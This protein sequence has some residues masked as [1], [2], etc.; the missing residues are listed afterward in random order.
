MMKMLD[1]AAVGYRVVLTKADKVKQSE[2]DKVISA[3]VDEAR[4]HP[5][6]FPELHVTSAEKGMGIAA[7]RSAVVA[8]A[9]GADW[10]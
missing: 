8:D 3:T 6:A 7:L 5:A 4:K 2:L 10:A 1:E 9:I